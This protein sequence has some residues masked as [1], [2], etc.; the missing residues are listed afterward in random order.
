VSLRRFIGHKVEFDD[1]IFPR[2]VGTLEN[3]W[4]FGD[5]QV[6]VNFGGKMIYLYAREVR[7]VDCKLVHIPDDS[8]PMR[9]EA[10][11]RFTRESIDQHAII[12]AHWA[13]LRSEDPDRQVGAV[14]LNHENRPIAAACNGLAKGVTLPAEVMRDR[15]ARRPYML[16][17]EQNLM[18]LFTRGEARLVALTCSPCE[19]C[20]AALSAHG[21]ERVIYASVYNEQ[22]LK[23]L[24][25]HR[26]EH[27]L[28]P[29]R[30]GVRI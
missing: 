8:G 16:H 19:S 21:V 11:P 18:A 4:G 20:A 15:D 10:R 5:S 24:D 29:L 13:R 27:E 23:M 6:K 28:V 25:S 17:A 7:P 26:I 3:V 12:G 9:F 14:A 1:G 2:C 30:E 22:G